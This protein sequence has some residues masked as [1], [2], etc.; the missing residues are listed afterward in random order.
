ME[1]KIYTI[2]FW[3]SEVCLIPTIVYH[4][5]QSALKKKFDL[6]VVPKADGVSIT[7]GVKW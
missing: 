1:E 5:K 7:M 2:A 6:S 3:I 4:F